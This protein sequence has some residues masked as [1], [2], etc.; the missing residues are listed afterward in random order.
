MFT[1]THLQ[2]TAHFSL[3]NLFASKFYHLAKKKK[4]DD[5]LSGCKISQEAKDGARALPH[6]ISGAPEQKSEER[7]DGRSH[8]KTSAVLSV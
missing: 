6:A 8:V 2:I 1:L 5:S 3:I 4:K 7:R